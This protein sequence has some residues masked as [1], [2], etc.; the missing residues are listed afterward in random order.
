MPDG[1]EKKRV[2]NNPAM[3]TCAS[4]SPDGK[5][6]V[7]ASYRGKYLGYWGIYVVNANGSGQKRITKCGGSERPNLSWSPFITSGIETEK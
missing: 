6:I 3:D 1:S 2:T 7:F 4:W 5:K